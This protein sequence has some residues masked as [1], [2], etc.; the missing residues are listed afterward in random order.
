MVG[1]EDDR[2]ATSQ[3]GER[4]QGDRR[5]VGERRQV[6]PERSDRRLRHRRKDDPAT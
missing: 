5:Q 6:E 4:R 1:D 2:T 3:G